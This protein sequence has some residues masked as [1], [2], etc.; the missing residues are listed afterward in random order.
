MTLYRNL[1]RYSVT[2]CILLASVLI[3]TAASHAQ[4]FDPGPS[5]PALFVNGVFNVPTD[6]APISVSNLQQLNVSDGGIVQDGLMAFSGGEVNISGGSVGSGLSASLDTEV[7]ISGGILGIAGSPFPP[8]NRF[9][10]GGLVNI[11][12]GIIYDSVLGGSQ[13]QYNITGGSIAIRDDFSTRFRSAGEVN[14]SGGTIGNS[15]GL[16]ASGVVNI[17]GTNFSIAGAPVT[18]LSPGQSLTV[19][20]RNVTL[21]GAYTDGS[22]FTFDLNSDPVVGTH[23]S[24]RFDYFSTGS[25]VT[26]TLVPSEITLLGDYNGN[27]QVDAADYTVWQDSFGSLFNLAADGNGNGVVD[28]ADYTVWQDNFGQSVTSQQVAVVP[29]PGTLCL[30]MC[31]IIW[32]VSRRRHE[33]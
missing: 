19:D 13:S 12:G 29:E 7:N 14:I 11:S 20:D 22:A 5:D 32:G 28:A 23:P 17:F 16:T 9:N 10:S 30:A 27:G 1:Y 3:L 4:V 18:S 33:C 8:F 31:G 25:T 21:N 26:I 6:T 15:F 24:G 2:P